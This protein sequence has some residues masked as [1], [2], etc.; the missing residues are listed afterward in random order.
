MNISSLFGFAEVHDQL[1]QLMLVIKK[2]K[3]FLAFRSGVHG[4][5][6]RERK[7]IKNRKAMRLEAQGVYVALLK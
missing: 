7:F 4:V 2:K 3:L 1:A 5:M 6:R